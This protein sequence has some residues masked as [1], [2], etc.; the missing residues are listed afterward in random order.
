MDSEELNPGFV[1]GLEDSTH[2]PRLGLRQMSQHSCK[3]EMSVIV[4]TV[5]VFSEASRGISVN[6]L[7]LL[8]S[9]PQF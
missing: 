9:I 5:H 8:Q 1:D 6:V 3:E 2:V 4:V 7:F